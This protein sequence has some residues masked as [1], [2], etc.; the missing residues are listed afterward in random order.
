[1]AVADSAMSDY[2]QRA[3]FEL[4]NRCRSGSSAAP[5]CLASCARN[6]GRY[7]RGRSS[8]HRR[9]HSGKYRPHLAAS[10]RIVGKVAA[11]YGYDVSLSEERLCAL[12]VFSYGYALTSSGK[13]ASLT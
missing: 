11:T 7:P 13:P 3:W 9:C 12:G 2:E 10:T 6:G 8:L 5:R 1:M 4:L